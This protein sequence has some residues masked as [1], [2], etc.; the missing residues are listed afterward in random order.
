MRVA[1]CLTPVLFSVSAALWSQEHGNQFKDLM[2]W[3]PNKET[4]KVTLTIRH[5]EGAFMASEQGFRWILIGGAD[6]GTGPIPWDNIRSWSCGRPI[7][8]TITTPNGSAEIGLKREDLLK[9]VNR[10]L[11]KYASAALDTTKG[12]S[13]EQF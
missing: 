7:G 4:F 9:V 3:G 11:K 13:P 12:C 6:T 8:L 10:Y 5:A 1:R 2:S